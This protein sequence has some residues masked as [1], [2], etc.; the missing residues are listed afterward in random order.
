MDSSPEPAAT[1]QPWR[2]RP[3]A[4]HR[5]CNPPL[6]TSTLPKTSSLSLPCTT[7]QRLRTRNYATEAESGPPAA[8]APEINFG[9]FTQKARPH[10]PRLP[11]YF[12]G[13]LRFTD[14]LEAGKLCKRMLTPYRGYER[15]TTYGMSPSCHSSATTG[16]PVPMKKYK[17]LVKILQRLN[18]IQ[19]DMVPDE[20]NTQRL[21]S[22]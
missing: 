21:A 1:H 18:R 15:S 10:H 17:S 16:E 20:C 12:S 5:R 19:P 13:S 8:A 11:S 6:P 4:S 9:S 14:H 3:T 2:A 7:P 22:W